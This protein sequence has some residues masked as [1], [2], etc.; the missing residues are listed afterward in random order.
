M[1]ARIDAGTDIAMIGAWDAQRS[2]N[3]LARSELEN[4]SRVLEAEAAEGQVFLLYTRADGGGPV[5]LYVDEAIPR[6]VQARLRPV[7][8]TFLLAVPS[9][10]LA[11]GGAEDYRASQPKITGQKSVVTIPRGDYALRC[12]APQNVEQAPSAEETLRT[13]VGSAELEY[14]DRI[15]RVGCLGGALSLL[16]FPILA[17][18]LGW[19]PA[20]AITAAV[21]LSFFPVMRWVLKGNARYQRLHEI[22]PTFRIQH[23]DPWLVFELRAVRERTGLKGGSASL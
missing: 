15:N 18:P 19:V 4:L 20:L 11:I 21:V 9:G 23:E 5:D 17:F 8:G 7:E 3:P 1:K 2:A 16:L 22:V 10:E 14:Y 13:L 6:E 12:Y